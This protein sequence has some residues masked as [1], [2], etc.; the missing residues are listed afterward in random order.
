VKL[1]SASAKDPLTLKDR[2]E[3]SLLAD[4]SHQYHS[5]TASTVSVPPFPI[6]VPYP[7][8]NG[9]DIRFTL[10]AVYKELR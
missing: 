1:I 2:D 8:N 9:K 10:D 7:L 4:R 3:V 5:S 6:P